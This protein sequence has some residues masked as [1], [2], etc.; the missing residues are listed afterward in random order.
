ML[1]L[2]PAVASWQCRARPTPPPFLRCRHRVP[3]PSKA[4]F[5]A[6]PAWPQLEGIRASLETSSLHN[7]GSGNGCAAPLPCEAMLAPAQPPSCEVHAQSDVAPAGAACPS[8]RGSCDGLMQIMGAHALGCRAAAM[9]VGPASE[10]ALVPPRAVQAYAAGAL[11]SPHLALLE[12][13][14][15]RCLPKLYTCM[16]LIGLR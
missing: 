10:P 14:K 9:G 8:S 7:S 11:A 2:P 5:S 1:Q 3:G 16:P 12:H 13:S 4:E 6:A 15:A